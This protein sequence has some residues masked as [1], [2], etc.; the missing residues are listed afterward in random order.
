MRYGSVCREP[1]RDLH[2]CEC[3]KPTSAL[4][5][6]AGLVGMSRLRAARVPP[7]I[8][9]PSFMSS[10]LADPAIARP[11]RRPLFTPATRSATRLAAH[12]KGAPMDRRRRSDGPRAR[13]SRFRLRLGRNRGSATTRDQR[14]PRCEWCGKARWFGWFTTGVPEEDHSDP[15]EGETRNNDQGRRVGVPGQRANRGHR[16]VAGPEGS[17]EQRRVPA[18]ARAGLR[19]VRG[20]SERRQGR[21]RPLLPRPGRDPGG[22]DGGGDRHRPELAEGRCAS[23]P[24]SGSSTSGCTAARAP[25]SVSK[26]TAA[27]GREHGIA[28][29]DGGCPCMFGPTADL[30]HKAMRLCSRS[31]AMSRRRSEHERRLRRRE[32][33]LP[34]SGDRARRRSEGTGGAPVTPAASCRLGLCCAFARS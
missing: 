8:S 17:R 9:L 19:G 13:T 31:T 33:T 4:R 23:A 14:R 34:G 5:L 6:V 25:G 3:G 20:Q 30:G 7:W 12:T 29:I 18:P 28:V 16:R 21:G 11:P 32:G 27:Y 24:S 15:E 2:G 1:T 22:V 10:T 26:A